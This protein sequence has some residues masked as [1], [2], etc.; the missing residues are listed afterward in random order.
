MENIASEENISSTMCPFYV[1]YDLRVA[2]SHLGS[3]DG[4]EERLKSV[5]ERLGLKTDSQLNGIYDAIVDQLS[6]S[7]TQLTNV[8]NRGI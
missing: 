5:K 8:V 6:S 3:K 4:S 1:L 2:Y 7:Y